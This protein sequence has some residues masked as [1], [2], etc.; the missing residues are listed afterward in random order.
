MKNKI[1]KKK[2]SPRFLNFFPDVRQGGPL[3]KEKILKKKF[4]NFIFQNPLLT[5]LSDFRFCYF[6]W[7]FPRFPHQKYLFTR[8]LLTP[9]P[10]LR[11]QKQDFPTYYTFSRKSGS[12]YEN[13]GKKHFFMSQN[14]PPY[15]RFFRQIAHCGGGWH[16]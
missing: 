5:F 1:S 16:I 10:P 14:T 8:K 3:P 13:I 2:F 9:D 6:S 4:R 15:R 12:S 7:N 11:H